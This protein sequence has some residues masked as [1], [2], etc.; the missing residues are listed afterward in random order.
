[1]DKT[2]ELVKSVVPDA[3]F[4]ELKWAM[5]W[6]QGPMSVVSRSVP[7][8]VSTA[9]LVSEL[10]PT[11]A[12]ECQAAIR[13][14]EDQS[15]DHAAGILRLLDLLKSGP[16]VPCVLVTDPPQADPPLTALVLS[17]RTSNTTAIATRN[18]EYE[19]LSFGSNVTEREIVQDLVYVLQGID[20]KYLQFTDN[21]ASVVVKDGAKLARHI[22]QAVQQLSEL[23]VMYL[24]ITS[25]LLNVP[26]RSLIYQ[27]FKQ[28]VLSQLREYV[29]LAALVD[30]DTG[31]WTI[32]KLLAWLNI[33][34]KKLRYLTTIV[35]ETANKSAHVLDVLFEFKKRK[36]FKSLISVLFDKT[37]AVWLEMVHIW[38]TCGKLP[39]DFFFAKITHDS[40]FP[41]NRH[42]EDVATASL[43]RDLYAIDT[44]GI[45]EFVPKNLALKILTAG[46]S[47]AFLR[48]CNIE[49]RSLGDEPMFESIDSLAG[50]VETVLALRNAQISDLVMREHGLMKECEMIKQYVLLA[51]GDFADALMSLSERELNRPASE[52]NQFELRFMMDSAVRVSSG[53]TAVIERLDFL[54]GMAEDVASSGF[55]V[56]GI[57]FLVKP[58]ID[59][60]LTPDAMMAYRLCFHSVWN[61][62]RCEH[63][64]SSS[65]LDLQALT[66]RLEYNG[67]RSRL[68]QVGELIQTANSVRADLWWF[69]HELRAFFCYDVVKTEWRN[70]EADMA[71]AITI[72][73]IIARHENYLGKLKEGLFLTLADTAIAVEI[74]GISDTIIRFSHALPAILSELLASMQSMQDVSQF[75]RTNMKSLLSEIHETYKDHFASFID[76]VG[77]RRDDEKRCEFFHK[78]FDRFNRD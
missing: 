44:S 39:E 27:A 31:Q 2:A 26:E 4:E 45:P 50:D 76:I 43:W 68:W 78:V 23:G 56:V 13:R 3:D 19:K 32:L 55:D 37:V 51:R 64:L 33:P 49:L 52:Q 9:A 57:D 58:P 15:P 34:S 61:L 74:H 6:I 7:I 41:R 40:A 24:R 36:I 69:I 53:D 46:K 20:G 38:A 75:R 63:A 5:R 77:T 62:V 18:A 54:I 70:F 65:W 35:E 28:A 30:A 17:E 12:V 25:L 11:K 47:S 42:S 16:L 8:A 1:M 22:D 21:P 72:D 73:E 71:T 14:L 67:R 60:V 66:K 59:V 10:P 48:I 29:S